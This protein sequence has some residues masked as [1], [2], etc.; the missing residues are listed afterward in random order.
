MHQTAWTVLPNH[1]FTYITT[2]NPHKR[3]RSHKHV[4]NRRNVAHDVPIKTS[5]RFVPQTIGNDV[6][7]KT[8]MRFVPQAISNRIQKIRYLTTTHKL[9]I[10]CC[11][12]TA[13]S[14]RRQCENDEAHQRRYGGRICG[15]V[16]QNN[17]S[18]I[19]QTHACAGAHVH[20]GIFRHEKCRV[21]HE[22]K[23]NSD[24]VCA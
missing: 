24:G 18:T 17:S 4:H 6:P 2:R 15:T 11:C 23:G 20:E 7:I 10:H 5:M 16:V 1:I 22:N 21:P 9:H 14:K 13:M 12:K 3:T 19:R 8:S